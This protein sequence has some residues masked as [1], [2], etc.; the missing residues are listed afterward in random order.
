M[1]LAALSMASMLVKMRWR[2]P[3]SDPKVNV[4]SHR[5]TTDQQAVATELG[6]SLS[7]VLPRPAVVWQK[8]SLMALSAGMLA[9]PEQGPLVPHVVR[10][11]L[12][13][14]QE[15]LQAA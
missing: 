2:P 14:E 4:A 12:T 15:E 11:V 1:P 13:S 7:L 8:A 9:A 10:A 3:Q 5:A 6:A